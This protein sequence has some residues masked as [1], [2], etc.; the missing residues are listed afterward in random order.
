LNLPL[1]I[2]IKR[3]FTCILHFKQDALELKYNFHSCS[4]DLINSFSKSR[5]MMNCNKAQHKLILFLIVFVFIKVFVKIKNWNLIIYLL[6]KKPGAHICI[7]SYN[8]RCA[9]CMIVD[10]HTHVHAFCQTS[11]HARTRNRTLSID[12]ETMVFTANCIQT[13]ARIE[14]S[15]L[16]K[17]CSKF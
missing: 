6:K 5:W 12:L 17:K 7:H 15:T 10:I 16:R 9:L 4:W 11:R 14:E 2:T 13:F 1:S 8:I 3:T